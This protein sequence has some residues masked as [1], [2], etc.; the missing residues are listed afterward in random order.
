MKATT[1]VINR[2]ERSWAGLRSLPLMVTQWLVLIPR[3][4]AFSGWQVRAIL[5][6]KHRQLYLSKLAASLITGQDVDEDLMHKLNVKRFNNKINIL[7][8]NI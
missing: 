6:F 5:T 2:V 1:L 3:W 8:E 7:K 4:K